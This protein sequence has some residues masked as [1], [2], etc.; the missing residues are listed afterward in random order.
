VR[1][2]SMKILIIATAMPAFF[3]LLHTKTTYPKFLNLLELVG[4]FL[5]ERKWT[6]FDSD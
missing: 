5:I 6:N 2:T 4:I 3:I 1:L